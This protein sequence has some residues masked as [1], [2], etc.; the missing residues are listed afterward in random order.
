MCK[1]SI[2]FTKLVEKGW[3]AVVVRALI[4]VYERQYAWVR[5]GKTSSDIFSV[6]NGTR[7]G[8]VLSPT[9]FANYMD[10]ILTSLRNL[11]VGC[12][13]GEVFMGA[14]GYADDLVLLAPSRTAM[15]LMLDVCQDFGKKNN[16]LFSTDPDPIKSKTKCVFFCGRKRV[17]KPSPLK[18][19]GVELPWVKS[20]TH[21][22]NELC[23]DGTM[24]TDVKIKRAAFIDRSLQLREQFSCA[25]PTEILRA[26][27][28]YCC[29][30][31]GGMLWEL[32]SNMVSQYFNTW[33]TC[34]KLA[35]GLP[36][37]THTYF[38]DF[39]SGGLV[40]ARIDILGR[41]LG[42]YRSLLSSPSREVNILARIVAKDIRSTT[43]K[44]LRLLEVETEGM[45]WSTSTSRVKEKLLQSKP[46]VPQEDHWRMKYLGNL[47]EQRDQLKYAGLEDGVQVELIQSLIDSLCSS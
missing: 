27:N 46:R 31:Y 14:L 22:G 25:H 16:L 45:T 21:L 47:L 4:V 6:V 23:E 42:F 28:V 1:Y 24:A 5:W 15:Q 43:A 19:Y 35:W 37:A 39:L 36:R 10:E 29:D 33:N 40:S 13:V 44:N 26:V 12:Y 7:Q 18:L 8:S 3:P 38:L 2:L 20:A 32:Q 9:L 30:H 11:G 41:Y 17:E 34:V